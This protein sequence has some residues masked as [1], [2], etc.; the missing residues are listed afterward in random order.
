MYRVLLSSLI[1]SFSFKWHLHHYS[2]SRIC[3]L[4]YWLR[5]QSIILRFKLSRFRIIFLR[6]SR[7]HSRQEKRVFCR[8]CNSCVLIQWMHRCIAEVASTDH[9]FVVWHNRF[10]FRNISLQFRL[11]IFNILSLLLIIKFILYAQFLPIKF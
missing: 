8:S 5:W 11:L 9:I 7:L 6:E 10:Y 4:S 3:K 1:L 2:F